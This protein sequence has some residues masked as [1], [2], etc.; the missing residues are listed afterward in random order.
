MSDT[1]HS[2]ETL[3]QALA[4]LNQAAKERRGEMEKLIGD[5]YADLKS[6]LGGSAQAS[7]DWLKAKGKEASDTVQ[8]AASGVNESVH[9]SPWHYIGGA[10]LGA[11][12][13]GYMLGRRD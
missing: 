10:A 4:L 5:K 8:A 13:L 1:T 11:L 3:N 9:K 2:A 12:I 6:V 7:T